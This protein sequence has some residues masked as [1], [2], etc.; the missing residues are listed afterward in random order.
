MFLGR[1]IYVLGPLHLSIGMPRGGSAGVDFAETAKGAPGLDFVSQTEKANLRA[2]SGP[3]V[4][5]WLADCDQ[6]RRLLCGWRHECWVYPI[7]MGTHCLHCQSQRRAD[8]SQ[9][10]VDTR[11]HDSLGC[12]ATRPDSQ[13]ISGLT[14]LLQYQIQLL[15]RVLTTSAR[16][17]PLG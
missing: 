7:M 10:Q 13:I 8:R 14:R 15:V 2:T 5:H 4:Y 12:Q 17:P 1:A 11:K 3:S 9:A 6:N 16:K